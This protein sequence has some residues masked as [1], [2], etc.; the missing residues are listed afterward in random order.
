LREAGS[1]RPISQLAGSFGSSNARLKPMFVDQ[2]RLRIQG[3]VIGV[4]RK[5]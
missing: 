4:L 2:D 5:Y 1:W 3:V